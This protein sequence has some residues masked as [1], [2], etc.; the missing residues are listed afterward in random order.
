MLFVKI[1]KLFGK[2]RKNRPQQAK[3][4]PFT[5][6]NNQKTSNKTNTKVDR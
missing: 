4:I 1:V 6:I 2:N 3:P 5:P